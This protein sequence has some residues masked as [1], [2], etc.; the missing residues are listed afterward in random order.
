MYAGRCVPSFA[1]GVTE[2][3]TAVPS[4][5]KAPRHTFGIYVSTKLLARVI[6]F[7]NFVTKS[8]LFIDYNS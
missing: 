1:R 6:Y 3:E 4:R 5:S 8:I 2:W 7:S